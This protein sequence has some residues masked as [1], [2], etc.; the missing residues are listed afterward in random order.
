MANELDELTGYVNPDGR[1]VNVIER[2]L[3]VKIGFGSVLFEI[4]LWACGIL[5]GLIFL[6]M[7][8]NKF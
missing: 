7:K 2:Q 1:D 4:M 6:F 8:I 3:P 5:P